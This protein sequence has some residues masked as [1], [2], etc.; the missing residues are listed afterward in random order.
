MSEKKYIV[1][2]HRR[3]D[4]NSIFYVGIGSEKRAESK[5]SRNKYWK[6]IVLSTPYSIEILQKNLSLEDACELEVFLISLYGRK[7]LKNGCLVNMS[8]GGEGAFGYTPSEK[9]KTEH[10]N[11][12]K[13]CNNPNFRGKS[14]TK[15]QLEKIKQPRPSMQGENNPMYG[16]KGEL[17]PNFGK[18]GVNTGKVLSEEQK[19]KISTSLKRGKSVYAKI[20]LDTNT[21]IFYDC[22]KDASEAY[23]INYST[24]RSMLQGRNKN[25]TDLIYC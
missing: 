25:K 20:V 7:D 24:L 11:R 15:E 8:S 19:L 18:I 9:T 10:S 1:Y 2:R 3:L 16:K 14:M 23:S 12:M 13:G 21:G 17:S 5:H 4:D 22:L 6:N